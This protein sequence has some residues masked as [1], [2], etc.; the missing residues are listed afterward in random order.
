MQ[1]NIFYKHLTRDTREKKLKRDK[2]ILLVNL[3]VALTIS[4]VLFLVGITLIYN[5][6]YIYC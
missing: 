2:E 1:I 4:Y 3:C 5:K 6:V